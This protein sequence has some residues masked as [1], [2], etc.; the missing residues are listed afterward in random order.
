MNIQETFANE[1]IALLERLRRF[2]QQ[3]GLGVQKANAE[4]PQDGCVKL[5]R[6][7]EVV[8]IYVRTP[9][10]MG[11]LAERA[12]VYGFTILE[13]MRQ[14]PHTVAR[15]PDGWKYWNAATSRLV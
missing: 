15:W 13:G 7:P 8:E 9:Q 3:S 6:G 4:W 1:A 5:T 2:G 11:S 14:T 10:Q 12:G